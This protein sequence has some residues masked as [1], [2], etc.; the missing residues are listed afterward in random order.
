MALLLRDESVGSDKGNWPYDLDFS[1]FIIDEHGIVPD[2]GQKEGMIAF[3]LD[4]LNF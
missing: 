2:L 3:A 4:F 1:P